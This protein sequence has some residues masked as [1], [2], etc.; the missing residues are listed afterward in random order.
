MYVNKCID[1]SV[2]AILYNYYIVYLMDQQVTPTIELCLLIILSSD[3]ALKV[4][5]QTPK[6]YLRRRLSVFK[7]RS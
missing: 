1:V 5:W 4:I 2:I 6:K 3:V 7:V